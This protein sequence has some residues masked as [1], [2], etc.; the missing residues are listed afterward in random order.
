MSMIKWC[1]TQEALQ[2]Y[3]I[4]NKRRLELE[5]SLA[6]ANNKV[7]FLSN[8]AQPTVH[9]ELTFPT[10]EGDLPENY[11]PEKDPT[12]PNFRKGWCVMD[13]TPSGMAKIHVQGTLVPTYNIWQAIFPDWE[14][15]YECIN[16]ALKLV[17]QKDEII[18]AVM[19]FDSGGGYA[20]GMDEC[21]SNIRETAK[22]KPISGYT[23]SCSFSASYGLMCA[24]SPIYAYKSA[25]VGS[26]GTYMVHM[27]FVDYYAK[28]GISPTV[29]RAGQFKALGLPQEELTDE[30]KKIM[31]EKINQ[32]NSFFLQTV[33][34]NRSLPLSQ[35]SNWGEGKTFF[36][37]EAKNVGLIDELGSFKDL[38]DKQV[39][40]YYVTHNQGE[41]QAMGIPQA[42]LDRIAAG[43]TASAVLS[44]AELKA[45]NA[46]ISGE[47]VEESTDPKTGEQTG[48][49]EGDTVETTE[50]DTEGGEQQEGGNET[51]FQMD[52]SMFERLMSLNTEVTTLRMEKAQLEQ[53][54]VAAKTAQQEAESALK[55]IRPLAEAS[56]TGL[57][58][59]LR[60]PEAIPQGHQA[61]VDSYAE[62][63]A[64]QLRLFPTSQ[65][66]N[67]ASVDMTVAPTSN[68]AE[69]LERHIQSNT[70]D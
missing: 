48:E 70:E 42:K 68:L 16:D 41:M 65:R 29:I 64:E 8:L 50:G 24:T 43:E 17:E 60:K 26:I 47:G 15:S 7:R 45:Y 40:S 32:A 19:V 22:L 63:R 23:G 28:E 11:S 55:S 59:V 4:H 44:A 38:F 14:T 69:K 13:V 34:D 62:L 39:V 33:S 12:N 25:E 2:N 37:Q 30:A 35:Q 53:S 9:S 31:Q 20:C 6:V 10:W 27:S 36:A 58:R 51:S 21:A 46:A 1:G 3:C 5:A 52:N 66:S 49:G 54:V 56:V 18:G 61:L 57:Q 67:S